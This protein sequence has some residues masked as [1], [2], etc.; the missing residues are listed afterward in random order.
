MIFPARTYVIASNPHLG[1]TLGAGHFEP[2]T[3]SCLAEMH[4]GR[5]LAASQIDNVRGPVRSVSVLATLVE[6]ELEIAAGEPVAFESLEGE[7]FGLEETQVVA[8][9]RDLG[10]VA[11]AIADTTAL[12]TDL[13][14]RERRVDV[15]LCRARVRA[16]VVCAAVALIDE[17]LLGDTGLQVHLHLC[18]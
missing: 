12:E 3:V 6:P 4:I 18:N 9:L 7:A 17:A 1:H 13:E 10:D 5:D 14:I 8:E 2:D 16:R 15:V 11:R